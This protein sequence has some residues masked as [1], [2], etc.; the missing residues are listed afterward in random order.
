MA[1]AWRLRWAGKANAISLET[2]IEQAFPKDTDNRKASYDQFCD[3]IHRG[4]LRSGDLLPPGSEFLIYVRLGH[5]ASIVESLAGL[6]TMRSVLEPA[7]YVLFCM[8][9]KGGPK[10]Q[11]TES[12]IR[13]AISRDR[14]PDKLHPGTGYLGTGTQDDPFRFTRLFHHHFAVHAWCRQEGVEPRRLEAW[15]TPDGLGTVVHAADGRRYWF[16]G[17]SKSHFQG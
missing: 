15:P 1:K 16:V 11:R 9:R 2:V 17:G 10:E 12:A 8:T 5:V 13:Q 4:G 14:L 6:D 7:A 3:V